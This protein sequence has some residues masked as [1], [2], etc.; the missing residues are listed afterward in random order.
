MPFRKRT[1]CRCFLLLQGARDR[2]ALYIH[3]ASQE[4]NGHPLCYDSRDVNVQV[5]SLRLQVQL[6]EWWQVTIAGSWQMAQMA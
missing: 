5:S 1:L 3:H 6:E 4:V 2:N